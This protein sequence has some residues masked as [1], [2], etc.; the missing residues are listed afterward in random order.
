MFPVLSDGGCCETKFSVPAGVVS[1]VY[2]G[3]RVLSWAG[4][5]LLQIYP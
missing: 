4:V 3:W 5:P 1:S 2:D